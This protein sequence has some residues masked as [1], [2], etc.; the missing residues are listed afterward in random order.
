[1]V[2]TLRLVPLATDYAAQIAEWFDD[3]DTVR[4]VGGLA[5]LHATLRFDRPSDVASTD[6][7][8]V[9][10]HHAW[11]ALADDQ[12]VAVID[13]LADE[14]GE[15]AIKMIVAPARRKMG[16]GRRVLDAVW[17]LPEMAAVRSVSGYVD[18]RHHAARRLAETAGFTPTGDRNEAGEVRYRRP[19]PAAASPGDDDAP[20]G[21]SPG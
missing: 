14:Q 13:V 19:G 5:W 12:P 2:A 15:A 1:V 18:P 6:L 11:L 9:A 3:A 16:M 20:E 7:G 21:S 4:F 8:Q 17:G 10:A